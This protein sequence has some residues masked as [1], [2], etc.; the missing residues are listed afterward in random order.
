MKKKYLSLFIILFITTT[1]FAHSFL[2][3][4]HERMFNDTVK[5][6]FEIPVLSNALMQGLKD[7][8]VFEIHDNKLYF[9][10]RDQL[11]EMNL[12]NGSIATNKQVN[13]FLKKLPKEKRYVSQIRVSDTA[14]YLT[15]FND[16]FR[17]STSGVVTRL[18]HS[19]RFILGLSLMN[20]KLLMA[21]QDTVELIANNGRSLA[22]KPFPQSAESGFR[23]ST[24]G[25]YYSATEE[26]SVW[27]F[28]NS[29]PN[30]IS[31]NTYPSISAEKIADPFISYVTDKYFIVFPYTKRNVIY[32][33]KKGINKNQ[34]YKNISLKGYNFTPS[35]TDMENEEGNPNFK[36]GYSNET[37]YILSLTK[38]KLRILSFVL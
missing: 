7:I 3:N 33:I 29:S 28:Q 36:I 35:Q 37:F 32:V 21:T 22:I 19:Y 5:K 27:E 16:L 15:V 14:Y 31:V 30:A 24:N 20:D 13:D 4:K 12:V 6:L 38:G 18:Y 8:D 26:D 25:I 11:I 10:N 1:A 2:K 17:I 9:I 34:L 23:K